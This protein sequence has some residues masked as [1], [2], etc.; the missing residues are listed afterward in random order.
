VAEIRLRDVAREAGVHLATAS[1]ALNPA[2]RSRVSPA[3]AARVE[4]AARRLGYEVN[5]AA[6]ALRTQRSAMVGV[7]IPDI[8]RPLYPPLMRGIVDAL[9]PRGY[10][11]LLSGTDED[12]ARER[13]LFN[14]L[15]GRGVDGFILATAHL[16]HPLLQEAADLGVPTVAINRTAANAPVSS[17]AADNEAGMADLVAHLVHLGHE[18]IAYIAGPSD[19]STGQERA[20]GFR[21][22]TR[23]QGLEEH[24]ELMV[25]AEIYSIAAGM[26]CT[27]QLLG[28]G[29]PF[30]AL[31]A[32]NDFLAL[33]VL[34]V[35]RENRLR[36][37]EQISVA[38]FTDLPMMDRLSPA[39]TTVRVPQYQM[40]A[41]AARVLLDEI[42]GQAVKR[43]VVLPVELIVRE[44]TAPP[45]PVVSRRPSAR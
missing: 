7:L 1:R 15:R 2:T 3:T 34:D 22:A 4:E 8:A 20:A 38:G 18:R 14:L 45:P 33:G 12:E 25:E 31:I 37:P 29:E 16:R 26:R 41:E 32:G 5:F 36:C 30:T 17:V 23:R 10:I 40:G 42:E 9:E 19:T 21:T 39:L 13:R 11:A 27:R 24:P 44:S 28:R 43:H 6:R 35:L